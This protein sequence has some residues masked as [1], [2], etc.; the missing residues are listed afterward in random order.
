MVDMIFDVAVVGGGLVGASFA[1]AMDKAGRTCVL[2]EGNRPLAPHPDEWDSRVYAVSPSS[3][4]F[5]DSLGV[6]PELDAQRLT[7]VLDMRVFGDRG[8]ELHFSAYQAGS[9]RLATVVEAGSLTQALWQSLPA[10]RRLRIECPAVPASL[11]ILDTH[12]ELGLASGQLLQARLVVGADGARSWLRTMAGFAEP[13]FIEGH[14]A[15]V[16]NFDCERAHRGTAYQWFGSEGVVAYLPLPGKRIS[17]VWSTT[18][19]RAAELAAADPRELCACVEAAGKRVLGGLKILTPPVTFALAPFSLK[20]RVSRR[21]A[22]IG[23]SAHVLHPLAG[24]GLNLGLEDAK[25]LAAM[26]SQQDTDAGG[27]AGLR[28]F[29]RSR[30]EAILA[31]RLATGGLQKLFAAQSPALGAVRNAGLGLTERLPFLKNGLARRAM[32]NG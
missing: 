25:S 24:Q 13:A 8:A 28:R 2:L 9:A 26:L 12:V 6:W 1:R 5:L 17:V 29:E 14:A 4:A 27:L 16:A 3:E 10:H 32:R 18:T 11:R 30:A 31:M 7:P 19:Q 15:V 22:L 21:V 23:D 20:T